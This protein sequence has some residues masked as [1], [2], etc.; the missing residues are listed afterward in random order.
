MEPTTNS[1]TTAAGNINTE[2]R[3]LNLEKKIEAIYISVEKTR[4]YLWWTVVITVVLF[5]LPLIGIV[6]AIP[7]FMSTYSQISTL[8]L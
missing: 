4:K 2:A 8:E 1:M 6:F 3:L 7:S 5:V